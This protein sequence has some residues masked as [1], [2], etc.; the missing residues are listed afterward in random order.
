M[1]ITKTHPSLHDNQTLV[2]MQKLTTV[3][4]KLGH[5][6]SYDFGLEAETAFA[7]ALDEVSTHLTPQIV[8]GEGN[9]VCHCE[10]DNLNKTTS[11]V[12][13]SNI[14]NSAGG[15]MVQEA[16][17][18]VENSDRR[19]LPV[20][21]KSLQ[22]SLKVDTPA[23]LPPLTFNRVGPKFPEGCTFTIPAEVEAVY[24]TKVQEYCLWLF[25][26][27][28]ASGGIQAVPALGGFISVTGSS[29]PRKSTIEYFTPIY[30]PITDSSVVREL[31]KRSEDATAEKGQKWVINT[32]DLGVCMKA[33]PI[34]WRWPNEFA[35]TENSIIL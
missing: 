31:L 30:Q 4:N 29:P 9:I 11:S 5:S 21:D 13:G 35:K 2:S 12:H 19:T 1:E 6:E 22:W 8:K 27:Y 33:H 7:K 34:I 20:S 25:A 26:Q 3:L 16:K 17:F 10:W 24:A 32:F 28:V 18:E 15:I 14:I 23:T